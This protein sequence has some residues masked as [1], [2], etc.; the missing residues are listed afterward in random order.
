MWLSAD[1][2]KTSNLSQEFRRGASLWL[3]ALFFL[4][5]FASGLAMAAEQEKRGY[6]GTN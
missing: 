2:L 1:M 4:S 5:F 6:K 3:L